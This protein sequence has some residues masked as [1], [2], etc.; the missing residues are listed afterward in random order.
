MLP[1]VPDTRP[2]QTLTLTHGDAHVLSLAALPAA[3]EVAV[4]EE[5]CAG[6]A[7]Q[8]RLHAARVAVLGRRRGLRAVAGCYTH[9]RQGPGKKDSVCQ[10]CGTCGR[11]GMQIQIDC[12]HAEP[13]PCCARAV[14]LVGAEEA[15]SPTA[16]DVKTHHH[17]VTRNQGLHIG[18][19]LPGTCG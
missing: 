8:L 9:V 1:D 3:S 5:A 19:N 15:S 6:L 14:Q 7:V 10:P 18:A 13:A 17:A 12:S 11:V 2:Q 4:P 16:A